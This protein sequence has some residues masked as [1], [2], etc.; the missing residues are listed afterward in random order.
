MIFGDVVARLSIEIGVARLEVVVVGWRRS[1]GSGFSACVGIGLQ[2]A[3]SAGLSTQGAGGKLCPSS[4]FFFCLKWPIWL[5]SCW[6]MVRSSLTV[7][8][9]WQCSVA[10]FG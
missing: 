7:G 5:V 2:S 8:R 1:L 10:G 4:F 3:D 9:R 6:V